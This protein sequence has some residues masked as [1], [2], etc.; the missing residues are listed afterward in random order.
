MPSKGCL[1]DS[2][3]YIKHYLLENCNQRI[4]AINNNFF[5]MNTINNN[6]DASIYPKKY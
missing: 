1:G 3:S 6:W 2:Y 5:F 4:I